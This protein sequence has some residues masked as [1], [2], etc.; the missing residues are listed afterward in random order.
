L[1]S[2]HG[3]EDMTNILTPHEVADL[4]RLQPD[5]VDEL[6]EQGELPCFEVFGERRIV[7]EEVE[8]FVAR[9]MA[10]ANMKALGNHAVQ[11]KA[12]AGV[13]AQDEPLREELAGLDATPG[14]FGELVKMAAAMGS[15]A[16]KGS[17]G[18][19]VAF[20]S[21]RSQKGD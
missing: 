14:T 9:Q 7:L 5:Q 13:L 1:V 3:K 18:N 17:Q 11:M 15:V 16:S 6:L 10:T 21:R 12:M 20:A 4:L 2:G 19:V 8:R